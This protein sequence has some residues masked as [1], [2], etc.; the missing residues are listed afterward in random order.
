L[1]AYLLDSNICVEYLRNGNPR[2]IHRVQTE[3]TKNIRLCS[4]VLG[5]LY[6]G[7]FRS[8]DPPKNLALL[9]KFVGKFTSLPFDDAAA[10]I[11]G[12]ERARLE[13]QGTKIGPHDMQIAAIALLHHLTVVT[14][15]VA[16][17]TRVPGLAVED[18]QV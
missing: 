14:H 5:E 11:Y 12:E 8:A 18:W 9:G 17:F 6:C 4:V 10:V 2:V 13:K 7:A 1:N 3:P 15:N 16:E